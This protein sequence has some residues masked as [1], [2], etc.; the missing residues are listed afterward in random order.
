M[1]RLSEIIEDLRDEVRRLRMEIYRLRV[2][3]LPE[4]EVSE[5]ELREIDELLRSGPNEWVDWEE[6]ERELL[7]E[8]R[9]NS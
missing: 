8:V 6:V 9:G 7:G 1:E 3:L 5:G 4:E 2:S